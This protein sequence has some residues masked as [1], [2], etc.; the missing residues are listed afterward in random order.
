[1]PG[2]CLTKHDALRDR[3]TREY[4]S[5][6]SM[7]CLYCEHVVTFPI[8][9]EVK[10]EVG[11]TSPAGVRFRPDVS[12]W[13]EEES[14]IATI[15]IVDS[16]PPR[17]DV[18]SAQ[19]ELSN[20]FYIS[21]EAGGLNF[22]CS[23]ECWQWSHGEGPGSDEMDDFA[24]HTASGRL[25]RKPLPRICELPRCGGCDVFLP[26]PAIAFHNWE[27]PGYLY[28][29]EC[30]A[31]HLDG[32]QQYKSPTEC[33][34]GITV[35]EGPDDV[36]SQFLALCD[37]VFWAK[38]WYERVRGEN[39]SWQDSDE[40]A[41]SSRLDEIEQAFEAEEW[42]SGARLLAAIG[43][44]SWSA[45]RDDRNPLYAWKPE[46][47]RRTAIEWGRLREWRVTQLPPNIR[48]LVQLPELELSDGKSTE[49]EEEACVHQGFS[50][51]QFTLCGIDRSELEEDIVATQRRNDVTCPECRKGL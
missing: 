37:A 28:C 8:G 17:T 22:W 29:L 33:M 11:V 42:E 13:G 47:C 4:G 10:K 3:L 19:Y 26:K 39:R 21:I 1:M 30:S 15:E 36:E 2:K 35:P 5:W 9:L 18:V 6:P 49:P 38:V 27:S 51:G 24:R 12:V 44:P 7:T 46:N 40:T 50:D 14:L 23:P 20:A 31:R 43:A 41:T 32:S 48:S 45:D 34:A 25:S 16:N